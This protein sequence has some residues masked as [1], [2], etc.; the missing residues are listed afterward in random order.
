M[1]GYQRHILFNTCYKILLLPGILIKSFNLSIGSIINQNVSFVYKMLADRTIMSRANGFNDL[2]GLLRCGIKCNVKLYP[3]AFS[4][5]QRP[6][7]P[8]FPYRDGRRVD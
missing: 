7:K 3:C 4:V 6:R 1:G 5:K 8:G 2:D